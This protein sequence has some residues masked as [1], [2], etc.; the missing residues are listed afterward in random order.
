MDHHNGDALDAS[1]SS[2]AVLIMRRRPMSRRNRR[3]LCFRE[4]A[5]V[6]EHALR[7]YQPDAAPGRNQ[8]STEAWTVLVDPHTPAQNYQRSGTIRNRRRLSMR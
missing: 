7:L 1:E 8:F 2:Q 3:G 4:S 5:R 6:G